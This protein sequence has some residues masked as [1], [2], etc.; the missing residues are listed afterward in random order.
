M[1]ATSSMKSRMSSRR[2]ISSWMSSRSK[3][4]TNV[5]LSLC[6]IS[7]L[8][9][10]AAALDV[11]QLAGQ[12][13][14]LVVVAEELLEQPGAGEHVLRIL[15]EE[16]EELLFARNERKAHGGRAVRGADADDGPFVVEVCRAQRSGS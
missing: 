6:P 2:L 12:P 11:A 9:L 7:W 15:D 10:V 8:M 1:S 4:V 3:G 14:A 16:L 5:V 13:L